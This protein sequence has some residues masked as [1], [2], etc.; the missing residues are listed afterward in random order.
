M[1]PIKGDLFS[2]TTETNSEPLI[3][4]AK[5][6]KFANPDKCLSGSGPCS[7]AADFREGRVMISFFTIFAKLV[8]VMCYFCSL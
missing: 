2:S 1:P 4:W 6:P 3:T 8:N 5:E 7:E